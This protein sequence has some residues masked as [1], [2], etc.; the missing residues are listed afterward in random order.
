VLAGVAMGVVMLAWWRA[1]AV[2]HVARDDITAGGSLFL[3]PL[4]LAFGLITALGF[5]VESALESW[6]AIYLRAEIGLPVLFGSAGV[7]LFH[8]AMFVGRLGS[9]GV[10]RRIGRRRALFI[11]GIV[12]AAGMAAALVT[13]LPP[14][15]IG[16]F[17]VVG[18]AVSGVAPAA[19]SLAG[20][21]APGRSGQAS[22]V[23][24]VVGYSGFL[25]AP[26]AIG[27]VAELTGLAGALTMVIGGGLLITAVTASL[28]L[29]APAG[30]ATTRR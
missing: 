10:Q 27:G 28:Y 24:T 20:D 29:L 15:I 30:S 4:F 1:P 13:D 7:A 25:V 14:L 21:A 5:F 19:F 22:A 3:R 16:G 18:L 26:G 6:S 12:L 17:V 23:V 9:I 11:A 8:A 2:R